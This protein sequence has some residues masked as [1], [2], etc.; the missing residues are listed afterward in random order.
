M[1]KTSIEK[2]AKEIGF[3]IGCSDDIVQSDLLNGFC[4]G[5]A[6]SMQEANRETQL[7][8]IADKLDKK[9]EEVL[10]ALVEYIKLK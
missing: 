3:D 1:I 9:S 10:T 2:L 5:I 8:Y 6:N 7:C 4:K